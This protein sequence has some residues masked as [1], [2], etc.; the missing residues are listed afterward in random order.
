MRRSKLRTMPTS[1]L[2]GLF[3]DIALAEDDA[4][5]MDDNPRYNRQFWQL[6]AVEQELKSRQGDERRALLGLY[7][8]SNAQMRLAAGLATLAVAPVE[9]R[10]LLQSIY[11]SKEYPQAGDAGMSL[12]NLDRGIF[13]PT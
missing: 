10:Q 13:K 1:E 3:T 2:V 9:A 4:I 7:T 8:H 6:E 12:I 5:L 11:D